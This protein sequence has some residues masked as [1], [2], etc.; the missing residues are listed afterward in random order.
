MLDLTADY[1]WIDS[2]YGLGYVKTR[3]FLQKLAKDMRQGPCA[4]V[5]KMLEDG[6]IVGILTETN[7]FVPIGDP[8]QNVHSDGLQNNKRFRF[9]GRRGSHN[10]PR[11]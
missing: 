1:T 7:Q 5:F 9:C 2:F 10:F 11:C 4:P 8:E 6:L 3:D